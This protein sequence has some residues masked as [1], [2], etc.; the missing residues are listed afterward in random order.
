[1]LRQFQSLTHESAAVMRKL[2]K[3]VG[4]AKG[5]PAPGKKAGGSPVIDAA[6]LKAAKVREQLE[7]A[8]LE[9]WGEKPH[10]MGGGE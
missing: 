3:G 1:M 4:K 7:R 6:Q 5:E 8:R 9:K 2:E 10:P